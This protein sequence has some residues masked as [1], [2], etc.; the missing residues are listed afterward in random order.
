VAIVAIAL[1]LLWPTTTTWVCIGLAVITP[2]VVDT[3]TQIR[4]Q[5]TA[6]PRQ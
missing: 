6:G 2:V 4:Q 1:I 3:I 5:R